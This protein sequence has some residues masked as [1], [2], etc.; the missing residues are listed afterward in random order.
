MTSDE[1]SAEKWKQKYYDQL[2]QLESGEKDWKALET[3]LKRAIGRISL[4]AEGQNTHL[5]RH[6]GELRS[7]LKNTV[8]R[9]RLESII[10]DIS[11]ILSQ[12]EESQTEPDRTAICVLEQLIT[13][14]KLHS[15]FDKPHKKLL[16]QFKQS[17]D[18]QYDALFKE[19]IKLLNTVIAPPPSDLSSDKPDDK[20]DTR[21]DNTQTDDT[22]PGFLNRLFNTNQKNNANNTGSNTASFTASLAALLT[23]IPWPDP[24]S[25]NA[26]SIILSINNCTDEKALDT[27]LQHLKDILKQWPADIATKNILDENISDKNTT[28]ITDKPPLET[29]KTC[30]IE[31]LNTLDNPQSPDGK[32][33][34]FKLNIR[35]THKKQDFDKII[36][37]LPQLLVETLSNVSAPEKKPEIP[38][39][40][41]ARSKEDVSSRFHPS[42]QELL[43]R[44]LEQLMVPQDLQTD[45]E[46]MK[47]RL[48]EQTEPSDWKCLL[49]D[50]AALINSIRSK[51]QQEKHEFESFLQQVTDRL[52]TMDNFLQTETTNLQQAENEGN[53]FDAEIHTNVN[54]IRK[55]VKD[56]TELSSL[57]KNVSSKLD[58]V[59]DHI[60][61]YR[62][63]ETQR[64]Q[65]SQNRVSDMH[66]RIQTLEQEAQALKKEVIEKNKQAMFDALTAIPNR[67]AYE[68]KIEEE[69]SRWKRFKNP[70]SLAIWDIDFF[71]KVNDTYGHKAGD[72]VLKTVAQLLNKRI[73]STDFLARYGGEEF[74]MLL[75]GTRQE[76]TLRLVNELRQQVESCGFHYHGD[77]VKIT[78]SCGIS[79]FNDNDSLAQVFDRADQ[80]L[81]RAKDNGRNQCVAAACLSD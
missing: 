59:L 29:R 33:T 73:R 67:L 36:S 49:K 22:K 55:D 9:T 57:K 25:D 35:D 76:E 42:I 27:S 26:K 50:V 52:K 21:A 47:L 20:P 8:D 23:S 5:D 71:K 77:S 53:D 44:L 64:I 70:L 3:T 78:V 72:K 2:D 69:I 4:A 37:Q 10:D 19:S 41:S 51:M 48:A 65:K 14:L 28:R 34:A 15:D 75:P 54:E 62:E 39:V 79:C 7:H 38:K 12:L 80:A 58:T 11:R 74:V 66:S 40:S 1:Q 60:K 46:K 13:P 6:L 45:V 32:L 63:T 61:H 30:L 81:Y 68:K 16:K 31:L 43:I 17:T 18:K 24:L 56:A